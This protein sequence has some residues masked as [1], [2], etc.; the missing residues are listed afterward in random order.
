MSEA[1]YDELFERFSAE[2]KS[3]LDDPTIHLGYSDRQQM[4]EGN[5]AEIASE[6]LPVLDR[7]IYWLK[8]NTIIATLL[9][10]GGAVVTGLSGI[11]AGLLGVPLEE[12]SF[13]LF[14]ACCM[15]TAAIGGM[16]RLTKLEKQRMIC[17]LVVHLHEASVADSENEKAPA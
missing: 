5:Y 7:R 10:I 13:P 15:G 12:L 8:V 1:L 14:L 17:E 4:K 16:W 11:D 3:S 9:L 6:K 2:S